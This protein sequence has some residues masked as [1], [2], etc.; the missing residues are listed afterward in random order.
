MTKLSDDAAKQYVEEICDKFAEDGFDF[1]QDSS[2]VKKAVREEFYKSHATNSISRPKLLGI[3]A[4]V[5]EKYIIQPDVANEVEASTSSTK[6]EPVSGKT[7]N[8]LRRQM[9]TRS[10]VDEIVEG[11]KK[12]DISVRKN[13]TVKTKSHVEFCN[14]KLIGMNIKIGDNDYEVDVNTPSSKDFPKAYDDLIKAEQDLIELIVGHEACNSY[15]EAVNKYISDIQAL[16]A[17]YPVNSEKKIQ[18]FTF[19]KRTSKVK[20]FNPNDA[21][22]VDFLPDED[23]KPIVEFHEE[24]AKFEKEWKKGIS[25][26]AFNALEYLKL[27]VIRT[28]NII[29]FEKLNE[30]YPSIFTENTSKIT[31]TFLSTDENDEFVNIGGESMA[32]IVVD[33][34]APDYMQLFI[35]LKKFNGTQFQ[36]VVKNIYSH[37]SGIVLHPKCTHEFKKGQWL[38]A[39]ANITALDVSKYGH[40]REKSIIEAWKNILSSEFAFYIVMF[41]IPESTLFNKAFTELIQEG[42]TIK[43]FQSVLYPISFAFTPFMLGHDAFMLPKSIVNMS[44][45]T[46]KKELSRIFMDFGSPYM[47]RYDYDNCLW[48]YYADKENG[49]FMVDLL[50]YIV[51]SMTIEK[52][53]TRRRSAKDSGQTDDDNDNNENEEEEEN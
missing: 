26:E 43:L 25:V 40:E 50:H 36:R 20:F 7:P 48:L 16:R 41:C 2:D 34:F 13:T 42:V 19:V 23:A 18:K 21:Y 44:E 14:S 45:I 17:K 35:D 1:S 31:N 38:Q 30:H 6:Q 10:I 49:N 39:H 32:K 4:K 3:I 24:L 22:K 52:K 27:N 37:R 5:T 33:K 28:Q 9:Q 29:K 11:E 46:Y 15:I 12:R 47:K 51:K 53:V 8:R